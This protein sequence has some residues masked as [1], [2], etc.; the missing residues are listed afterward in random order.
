[1]FPEE[2]LRFV[3]V[4]NDTLSKG[5]T[6]SLACLNVTFMCPGGEVPSGTPRHKSRALS[7][8]QFGGVKLPFSKNLSFEQPFVMLSSYIFIFRNEQNELTFQ[9]W[10]L[11]ADKKTKP[12]H[13][14]E[15][16]ST[17][18]SIS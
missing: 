2:G 17:F 5:L 4:G 16:I 18:R 12:W 6:G 9:W 3:G 13:E 11:E 8:Y 1:M 15:M 10:F 7:S 14:H